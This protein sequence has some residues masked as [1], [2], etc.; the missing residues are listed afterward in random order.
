MVESQQ[1]LSREE[2]NRYAEAVTVN[3]HSVHIVEWQPTVAATQLK[4]F[5]AAARAEG[6]ANYRV[7][8]PDSSETGWEPVHGREEYVPVLYA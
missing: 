1:H 6:L 2:F 4:A 3:L 5:E 7:I 8:Q